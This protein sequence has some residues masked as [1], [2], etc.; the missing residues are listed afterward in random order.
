MSEPYIGDIRL[1][2]GNFAPVGWAFCDGSLLPISEYDP[3][4][5]LIGTNYGGDGMVTFALPD[6]R[7]RAPIH[8]GTGPGLSPRPIGSSA[9]S[10]TV[11]LTAQQMPAH[12]HVPTAGATP[13]S[14]SPAG[15]T[16]SAQTTAAFAPGAAS[17]PM[18]PEA[19]GP[20]G[21]SQPHDNMPP[22]AVAN[23]IIALVGV[24]PSRA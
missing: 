18:H 10:E 12:T 8:Q 23:Y 24:F 2:G 16:W 22:F 9:G 13:T 11:V 4:F 7:G 3:L 14:T 20:A 15:A 5:A 6:L 17:V 19:I 21:G 1:F